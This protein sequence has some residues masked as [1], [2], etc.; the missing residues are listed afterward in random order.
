MLPVAFH[1][2]LPM[3]CTTHTRA[4]SPPYLPQSPS[5]HH[6][7]LSWFRQPL[8]HTLAS[9]LSL[10]L[11]N[12]QFFAHSHGT[13]DITLIADGRRPAYMTMVPIFVAGGGGGVSVRSVQAVVS[14]RVP[15]RAV[16]SLLWVSIPK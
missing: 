13:L 1:N 2:N 6:L 7:N 15:V 3:L 10:R 14:H 5:H 16:S 8:G 9:A 11:A 4:R 12:F